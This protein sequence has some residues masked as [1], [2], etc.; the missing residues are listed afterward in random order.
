MA[1]LWPE[2]HSDGLVP[3]T[4]GK[5]DEASDV[6]WLKRSCQGWIGGRSISRRGHH[7]VGAHSGK[8]RT[9]RL[10]VSWFPDMK[11][12]TIL[13]ATKGG[14]APPLTPQCGG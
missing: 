4:P 12:L 3:M 7:E 13:S 8:L 11:V 10:G 6:P 1:K 2:A 14:R 9:T 5:N